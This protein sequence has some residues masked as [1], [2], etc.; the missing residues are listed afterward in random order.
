MDNSIK[1]RNH[2]KS[3][4]RLDKIEETFDSISDLDDG[5][6][7]V[8]ENTASLASPL[9]GVEK[10]FEDNGDDLPSPNEAKDKLLPDYNIE[11]IENENGDQ[12]NEV[13][14]GDEDAEQEEVAEV[15][16]KSSNRK[17]RGGRQLPT[18]WSDE[19]LTEKMIKICKQFEVPKKRQNMSLAVKEKRVFGDTLITIKEAIRRYPDIRRISFISCYITD[20]VFSDIID[21]IQNLK[22]LEILIITSNF[23]TQVAIQEFIE[24]VTI[25]PQAK[26]LRI[27]DMRENYLKPDDG[28]KLYNAFPTITE[29]N[30]IQIGASKT[31]A[32][33]MSNAPSVLNLSKQHLKAVEV[34]IIC[35]LLQDC[36]NITALDL[37]H[38]AINAQGLYVLARYL[39]QHNKT[40]T[41]I[42]ISY[43]PLME[44]S[45]EDVG[46]ELD[47]I[48]YANS[49]LKGS[50]SIFTFNCSGCKIPPE[51]EQSIECSTQVNRAVRDR[52]R[53]HED[54]FVSHCTDVA[55]TRAKAVPQ[56][57]LAGWKTSLKVD[58]AFAK[59]LNIT[60]LNQVQ[61]NGDSITLVNR[62]LF[63]ER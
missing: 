38:N 5:Q 52:N 54:Y 15:E 49:V 41:S 51:L 4:L 17:R 10:L 31:L 43:N 45:V 61:V 62:F 59:K 3:D 35:A 23:I 26:S 56:D 46:T 58:Q 63:A 30:G 37:S 28:R 36:P 40:V 50:T 8:Q 44:I 2:S 21:T 25:R 32:K 60:K 39:D 1:E 9:E 20:T 18:D 55:H 48:N 57:P 16:T 14:K 13:D 7:Y 34:A 29:L 33:S 42:D 22:R 6:P 53:L 47:A 19:D 27:L 12:N 11:Q 24:K